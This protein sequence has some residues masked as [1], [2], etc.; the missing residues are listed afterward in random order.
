MEQKEPVIMDIECYHNY[1][2]IA[3]MKVKDEKLICFELTDKKT[4]NPEKVKEI[5]RKYEIITFN[6]NKYDLPL[7]KMALEGSSNKDLKSQSDAI[8]GNS[9]FGFLEG[10]NM[11]HIDIIEL[12]PLKASLKIYGARLHCEKLQELP[13]EPNKILTKEEMDIIR[14]YCKNDLLVT[15]KIFE[16]IK[17]QIELRRKMSNQYGIDLRSK[18]DA[19]IA[20][21]VIKREI[22]NKSKT[23]IGKAE[24]VTKEFLYEIPDFIETTNSKLNHAIRLITEKP[25][26]VH[27]GQIQM[28]KEL[29]DFKIKI[30]STEYRLGMGGL[31]STEKAMVLKQTNGTVICDWD[32]ASYYPAII[33]NCGYYPERLGTTFL[34]VYRGIVE[35]RL[36]AKKNGDKIKAD[37]LK[38]TI[39]GA[40]GKLGSKYSTLYAPELMIQVTVTGQ[41]SLLM[42]IVDLELN[43]I[44]VKSA[45]TD[46]IV[47]SYPVGREKKAQDIIHAWEAKTGF[48]MERSD[49]QALYSKDVNNYIAVKDDGKVKT[50]GCFSQSDLKKNPVTDICSIA[51]IEHLT[52][53]TDLIEAIKSCNDFTKFITVR[54]VNG[55]AVKDGKKLGKSIRWYYSKNSKS[56]IYYSTGNQVPKS[57]SAVPVMDLPEEFPNDINYEWYLKEAKELM[58]FLGLNMSGQ[59]SFDF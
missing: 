4:F 25:F 22:F 33:L 34:D 9:I 23:Y 18:S 39:N 8:I 27:D 40:F 19:Q 12:T 31:H 41:L 54:Q 47:L 17:P 2:L 37:A 28:P 55:G 1:F 38:I 43:G 26:F 59:T 44:S 56:G 15:K 10:P 32:V 7:L 50:K 30:G 57:I 14:L 11:D 6:G 53:G 45:N 42:L 29:N 46:G 24:N 48:V 36:I 5:L 16:H 3:F 13:I 58:N 51:I 35:E 21:T 20:E 49:Y 52:K